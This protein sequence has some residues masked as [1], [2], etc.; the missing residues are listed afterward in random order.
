MGFL[1]IFFNSFRSSEKDE[2]ELS[3]NKLISI[4]Q[5]ESIIEESKELPVVIF[6]HST[7][8]GISRMVLREFQRNY[9]STED[10]IKL[11]YLDILSF[12]ELSNEVSIKFQVFHESPQL[13]VIKDG[14]TIH[15][16]SHYR[17]DARILKKYISIDAN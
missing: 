2:N 5:L 17:I 6:K 13:L 3:W 7:S 4:E 10:Q 16:S 8:C 15:H 11:Y 12:I 9:S 14:N 1:N